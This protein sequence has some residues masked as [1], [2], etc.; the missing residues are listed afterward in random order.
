[1]HIMKRKAASIS[2]FFFK[3][4]R[5]SVHH[6]FS[7][8]VVQ[9]AKHLHYQQ[10]SSSK[11]LKWLSSHVLFFFLSYSDVVVSRQTISWSSYFL[12]LF[13]Q[14]SSHVLLFLLSY[15]DVV[16]S[17]QAISLFWCSLIAVKLYCFTVSCGVILL[18]YCYFVG[19]A[20]FLY[21]SC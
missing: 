18:L 4:Y 8:S 10:I 17:R 11:L 9:S 16:V 2:Y 1:M 13:R 6:F 19:I 7:L 5:T 3:I 12:C 20:L 21:F 14:L 15:S